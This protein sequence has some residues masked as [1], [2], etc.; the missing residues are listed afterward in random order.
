MRL[1]AT[2]IA[3]GLLLILGRALYPTTPGF[4][5]NP[6]LHMQELPSSEKEGKI[7]ILE[8]TDGTKYGR[9]YTV[10]GNLYW[11]FDGEIVARNSKEWREFLLSNG[12]KIVRV[13]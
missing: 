3:V 8:T 11:K 10:R 13:R 12:I 2:M 7:S 1:I 9:T 4:Y 6:N 5:T